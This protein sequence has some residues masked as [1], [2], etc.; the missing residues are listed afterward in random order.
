MNSQE[1]GFL[2]EKGALFSFERIFG[3]ENICY[4]AECRFEI[5]GP[6]LWCSDFHNKKRGDGNGA[7]VMRALQEY[8]KEL[9]VPILLHPWACNGMTHEELKQIYR[10]FGFEE[11]EELECWAWW[12]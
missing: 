1:V 2:K 10:H 4:E 6:F 3:T 8:A 11:N 9:A 5:I 7:K 12:P